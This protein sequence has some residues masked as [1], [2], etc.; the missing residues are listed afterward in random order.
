MPPSDPARFNALQE[1]AS[2]ARIDERIAATAF[3]THT[4]LSFAEVV[5][6]GREAAA[7]AAG[8]ITSV[9][10][11]QILDGAY[12]AYDVMRIGF[13]RVMSFGIIFSEGEDGKANTVMLTVGGYTKSQA[14]VLMIGVGRQD[15]AGYGPLK[16]FSEHM[17]RALDSSVRGQGVPPAM[18]RR[19]VAGVAVA[20]DSPAPSSR[21]S[22][23]GAG[24]P[25]P[26]P[27]GGEKARYCM[28][29]GSPVRAAAAF[30][31]SCGAKLSR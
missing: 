12:V 18:D 10:E 19:N 5:Q 21:G 25:S 24:Q 31:G 23:G 15:A 4:S 29:C 16:K 27:G 8:L 17:Q 13:A 30:C 22:I 28:G 26:A 2:M 3:A 14:Q 6:I 1:K 7:A 11:D 20:A 9:K